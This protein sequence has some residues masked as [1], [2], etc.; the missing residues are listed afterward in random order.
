M[1]ERG[2]LDESTILDGSLFH[3]CARTKVFRND[4]T[5]VQFIKKHWHEI[6]KKDGLFQFKI[7]ALNTKRTTKKVSL[8]TTKKVSLIKNNKFKPYTKYI[9]TNNLRIFA[10]EE[11]SDLY[12]RDVALI[13][14]S[15]FENTQLIDLIKQKRFLNTLKKKNK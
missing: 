5:K 8:R 9:D 10:L 1:I 12:I 4:D 6:E 11:V 15:M 7:S 13:Y 14:D 3:N 2:L